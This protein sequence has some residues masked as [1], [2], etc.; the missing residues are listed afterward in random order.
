MKTLRHEL[1]TR[2]NQIL[3]YSEL[4]IEDMGAGRGRVEDV[5]E[6]REA[7][8]RAATL[9]RQLLAFSRQQMLRP[10]VLDLNAKARRRRRA[11]E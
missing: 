5:R 3:G 10:R 9:T 6:I 8:D 7:A 4:L 1:R 2:L 11:S